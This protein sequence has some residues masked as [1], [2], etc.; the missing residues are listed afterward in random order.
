MCRVLMTRVMAYRVRA[1]PG[2][3]LREVRYNYRIYSMDSDRQTLVKSVDP[4]QTPQNAVSDQCLH[5]LPL[6]QQFYTH[7]QAVKWSC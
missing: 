1:D 6:C 4:D 3:F 7:S 5:C 2:G